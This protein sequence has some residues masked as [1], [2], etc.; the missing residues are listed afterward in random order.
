MKLVYFAW[1]RD[2]IGLAEEDVA[3]PEGVVTVAGVLDWLEGRGPNYA[4]ALADRSA[5]RVAVNHAFARPD[6]PVGD[7]DEIAVFPPVTGG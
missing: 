6:D 7:A 3:R 4:Q 5:I 2:R 1:V